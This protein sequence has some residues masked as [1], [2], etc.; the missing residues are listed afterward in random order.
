MRVCAKTERTKKNVVRENYKIKESEAGLLHRYPVHQIGIRN[1]KNAT[2]QNQF[3]Y[4]NMKSVLDK[5]HRADEIQ[6]NKLE[7]KSLQDLESNI[8][9]MQHCLKSMRE[10]KKQI[11]MSY[12][13]M[14]GKTDTNLSA[15][16][17]KSKEVGIEPQKMESYNKL[18]ALRTEMDNLMK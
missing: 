6:I 14:A 16:E 4:I 18:K 3:N 5:I 13:T 12:D 9:E 2:K 17:M 8:V 7:L 10:L 11:K 15:Y 1:L